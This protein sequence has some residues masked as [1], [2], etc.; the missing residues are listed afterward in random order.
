MLQL[1]PPLTS[2]FF[3]WFQL[4][5]AFFL[6]PLLYLSLEGR[7]CIF[8]MLLLF[9]HLL[10]VII[11]I[12]ELINAKLIVTLVVTILYGSIFVSIS[13][14][15]THLHFFSWTWCICVPS[16]F[17]RNCD[18]HELERCTNGYGLIAV[19]HFIL[20]DEAVLVLRKPV[21]HLDWDPDLRATL[22]H[23]PTKA[24]LLYNF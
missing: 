3:Q 16:H 7:V 8:T 5:G 9:N 4:N 22:W 17:I 10:W 24:Q 2:R 20:K 15:V 13:F 21:W 12:Y 1:F 14:I 6:L 18:Y 23:Y 19:P 11:A